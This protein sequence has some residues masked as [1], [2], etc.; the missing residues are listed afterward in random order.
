MTI[1]DSNVNPGID[2]DDDEPN[3]DTNEEEDDE[4]DVKNNDA[5]LDDEDVG[6][7]MNDGPIGYNEFNIPIIVENFRMGGRHSVLGFYRQLARPFKQIRKKLVIICVPCANALD[8]TNCDQCTW[9]MCA[10]FI[11]KNTTNLLFHLE[12][13]HSNV[14]IVKVLVSNNKNKGSVASGQEL[15]TPLVKVPIHLFPHLSLSQ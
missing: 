11:T 12:N 8:G 4:E 2:A 10:R 5:T 13:K 6:I 1:N 9:M 14:A 7:I 3:N 15:F